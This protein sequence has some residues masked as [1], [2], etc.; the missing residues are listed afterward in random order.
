VLAVDPSGRGAMLVG[1]AQLSGTVIGPLVA[2]PVVSAQ[3]I[4]AVW[5]LSAA[6][7][8]VSLAL[9]IAAQCR[10]KTTERMPS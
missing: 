2:A 5:P 6:W 3:G 10:I 7:L 4:A 9:L 8:F 1:T